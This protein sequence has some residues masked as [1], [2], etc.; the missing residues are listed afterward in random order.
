MLPVVSGE[1]TSFSVLVMKDEFVAVGAVN[2]GL[3]FELA[4]Y[5]VT[6]FAIAVGTEENR[7]TLK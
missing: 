3:A 1:S 4:V 6:F 7:W 2:D 5:V